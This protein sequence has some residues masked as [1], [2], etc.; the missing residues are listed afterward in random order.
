MDSKDQKP[1]AA[2]AATTQTGPYSK[3]GP[4]VHAPTIQKSPYEPKVGLTPEDLAK[5]SAT[6]Q[7]ATPTPRPAPKPTPMPAPAPSPT[8]TPAPTPTTTT[9]GPS[10]NAPNAPSGFAP[11]VQPKPFGQKANDKKGGGAA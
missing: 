2:T 9:T 6:A 3:D 8:P 7:A 5:T 4:G 1:K 10:T 11:Q